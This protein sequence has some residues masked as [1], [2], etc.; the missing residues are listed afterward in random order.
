MGMLR[1]VAELAAARGIASQVAVEE[2]M[3]CG[4]GVCM[5][6]VLPV[7]GDDGLTRMVRSCVEGPVFRGRPGALG[8]PGDR[9]A[10]HRRGEPGAGVLAV[11]DVDLRTT[12]AG[13]AFPNPVFTASGC[14]AAGQE[15]HQFFDVSLLGGVVTKSIMLAA[16][17]GR[18]DAAHGRD[19]QRDGQLDRAAGA[20][21]RQLPRA[22]PGLA[23]RPRARAVVSIAGGSV[24]D[25]AQ[26]ATRAARPSRPRHGRGQHLLPQRRGPRPGV[27][28]RRAGRLDV[29]DAVR[30]NTAPDI[31]VFAKLSPD[32][33][34]SPRS[35]GPASTREPT[36]CRSSTP[37]SAWSSTPRPC[38]RCSAASPGALRSGDPAGRRALRLAGARRAARRADPRHGRHPHRP[39]RAEFLLAGA[40]AVSVGTTVF[41]D[42]SAPVRVLRRARAGARRPRHR[43]AGDVVG[44]ATPAGG[45]RAGWGATLGDMLVRR[46]SE[47]IA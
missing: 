21:H 4:I 34:T 8:R 7:V 32:V 15:L 9:P 29:V 3:A 6:C 23:R 37:C 39:R 14:A 38:G 30:R 40:S 43:P 25:Y 11:S 44:L 2:S 19:A 33:T 35:R 27:R 5:T 46:P 10:G 22:R 28:V 17:S 20:G 12:L 13:V 16:R 45:A 18:A 31:P 41:G 24:D 26:L 36:A 47:E 1:A 42:P